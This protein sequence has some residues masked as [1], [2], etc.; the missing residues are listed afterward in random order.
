MDLQFGVLY[1]ENKKLQD[2]KFGKENSTFTTN[3][4]IRTLLDEASSITF[5]K[6]MKRTIFLTNM[7]FGYAL[8]CQCA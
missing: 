8:N 4:I 1:I 7:T 6:T 3:L 2:L 5:R